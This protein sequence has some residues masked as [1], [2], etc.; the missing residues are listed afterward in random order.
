MLKKMRTPGAML[1][2]I[3]AVAL[4]CFVLIP[5]A[6]AQD[7]EPLLEAVSHLEATL[8]I[9]LPSPPIPALPALP[10]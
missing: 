1:A 10:A 4:V 2:V 6:N 5:Q 8:Q 9:S 3:V 7:T